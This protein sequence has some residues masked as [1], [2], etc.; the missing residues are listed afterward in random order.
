MGMIDNYKKPTPVIWRKIG[1]SILLATMT[2]SGMVMTLPI[3]EHQKL[4]ANFAINCLGIAG[5]IITNLFVPK[6]EGEKKDG[7]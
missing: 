6:E 3:T 2:M 1:D 5:K 7:Q 4:W